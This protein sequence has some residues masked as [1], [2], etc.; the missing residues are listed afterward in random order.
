MANQ[1]DLIR[2]AKE[3]EVA[4]HKDVMALLTDIELQAADDTSQFLGMLE[5]N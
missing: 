2:Q 4:R 3:Q 5:E 1:I